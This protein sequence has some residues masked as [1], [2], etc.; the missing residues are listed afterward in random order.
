MQC[1]VT[2][3][4]KNEDSTFKKEFN[5]YQEEDVIRIDYQCPMLRKMI[6]QAKFEFKGEPDEIR[7]SI[8]GYWME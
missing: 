2:I 6:D 1:K 4:L 3:I 7:F 5:E 8:S